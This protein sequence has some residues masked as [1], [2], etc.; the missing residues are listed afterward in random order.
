MSTASNIN[1]LDTSHQD[2][3]QIVELEN[4]VY[5]DIVDSENIP[6]ETKLDNDILNLEV[7]QNKN[8]L[9]SEFSNNCKK[10]QKECHKLCPL[11]NIL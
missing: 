10:I 7:I 11:S 3:I 8:L 4:E 9:L 1:L 6:P 5:H 2:N